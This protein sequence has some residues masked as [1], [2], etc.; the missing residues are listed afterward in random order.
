[1]LVII[2]NGSVPSVKANFITQ[3]FNGALSLFYVAREDTVNLTEKWGP[4][5]IQLASTT[6]GT[7]TYYFL[8]FVKSPRDLYNSVMTRFFHRQLSQVLVQNGFLSVF[9]QVLAYHFARS[10][11]PN[12]L[13]TFLK[14][15]DSPKVFLIDEFVSIRIVNLK[16]LKEMGPIAYVSQD[17]A[18]T[19][20]GFDDH[21]ITKKLMYHF[22]RAAVLNADLVIACSERDKLKYLE[23][24]AKN[25][26]FYPNVYPVTGFEAEP[27][28]A[29]PSISIVLRGHWGSQ[30][31]AALEEIL[32]ALSFV[33]QP[34]K[35]YLIG[36]KP[37]HV[38]SN[39]KLE[40][41][42]DR[43]PTKSDF[44]RIISRSWIGINVGIHMGGSN[45]RKYDYSVA[46][47][48]VMSDKLGVR[49]DLIPCEYSYVDK[50][51]L[52]AKIEQL[53]ELGKDRLV[54]MGKQNR[55][56]VLALAEKQRKELLTVFSR[57]LD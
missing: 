1:M 27:K 49:G 38:P 16:R 8:M 14:G 54:E 43:I 11:K 33:R 50:H 17:I 26:L 45:E 55:Q 3:Q 42:A 40:H 41:Y 12:R 37:T 35:V 44:L 53:L 34:L 22:E 18:H 57:F 5:N 31:K 15:V 2:R 52:A 46:G 30:L 23:M 4:H 21:F 10:G 19:R 36:I 20:F 56:H 24:G 7:L 32:A 29:E 13:M 47:L 51:D 28:D 48:V 39:V 25:V 9:S 6:S